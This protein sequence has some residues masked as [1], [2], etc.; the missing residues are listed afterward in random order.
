MTFK[1][2][3]LTSTVDRYGHVHIKSIVQYK[4]IAYNMSH[5]VVITYI[6]VVKHYL[7]DQLVLL[8][9]PF[10]LKL[11]GLYMNLIHCPTTT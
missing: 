11:T 7:I 3:N 6:W 4:T 8:N 1:T 5:I 10:S 2:D 9:S